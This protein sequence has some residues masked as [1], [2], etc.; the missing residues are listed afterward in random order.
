MKLELYKILN[1]KRKLIIV[2]IA[3]FCL[4]IVSGLQGYGIVIESLLLTASIYMFYHTFEI[5]DE[6]FINIRQVRRL[7]AQLGEN[8]GI[9]GQYASKLMKNYDDYEYRMKTLQSLPIIDSV[10]LAYIKGVRRES[11][12]LMSKRLRSSYALLLIMKGKPIL[13]E[14]D[15]K[16][17][18]KIIEKNIDLLN[19]IDDICIE[20]VQGTIDKKDITSRINRLNYKLDELR[21]SNDEEE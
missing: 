7:L 2:G 4:C 5:D 3:L 12:C 16:R 18:T 17:I 20:L 9:I 6:Q 19:C 10:S 13:S 11:D 1:T 15:R 21:L 14:T 8:D